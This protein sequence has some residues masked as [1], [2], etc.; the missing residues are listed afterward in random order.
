MNLLEEEIKKIQVVLDEIFVKGFIPKEADL[1][2]LIK[3]SVNLKESLDKIFLNFSKEDQINIK[4]IIPYETDDLVKKLI[5]VY[6][7]IGGYSIVK[8][9]NYTCNYENTFVEYLKEVN[10]IPLLNPEEEIELFKKYKTNN[11]KKAYDSL[12]KANLR[13]VINI[14]KKYTYKGVDILDLIQEGNMGLM[15]SIEKFDIDK[16]CKLSTYATFWIRTY[17]S[18]FLLNKTKSI[19]LPVRIISKIK[20]IEKTKMH[21]INTNG[22]IPT[23]NEL[24]KLL[25][26]P[27]NKIRL[28]LIYSE[29][30][31]SLDEPLYKPE[32]EKGYNLINSIVDKDLNLEV[33]VEKVELNKLVNEMVTNLDDEM[34]K[35]I[36]TL[37]YGLNGKTKKTVKE[38]AII[39]GLSVDKVYRIEA[40][41]LRKLR[42]PNKI[43]K[44][45]GFIN[46]W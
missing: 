22:K 4:K 26:L 24:S 35:N 42:A 3:E 32:D 13:L 6:L 8:C 12:C 33:E 44:L 15:K 40:N 14:A 41:A 17:I 36:I 9:Q 2:Y 7:R 30:I 45:E 29:K 43:Y 46:N 5:L 38:I 11:D 1:E 21:Y 10:K 20:E 19:K 39:Y 25:N 23:D 28:Y 31:I 37:K 18:Y 27:I 34:E 16:N